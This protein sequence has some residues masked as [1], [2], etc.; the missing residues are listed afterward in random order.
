[1]GSEGELGLV[2]GDSLLTN[3][4]FSI[5]LLRDVCNADVLRGEGS[6]SYREF[7]G[8]KMQGTLVKEA[9][10]NCRE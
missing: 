5:D 8:G 10:G 7:R 3:T 9:T 6:I 1:M 4:S 2:T